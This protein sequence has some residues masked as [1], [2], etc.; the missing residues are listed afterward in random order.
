MQPVTIDDRKKELRMLLE[1]IQARPS[2]DWSTERERVVV[3][4]QMI[5]DQEKSA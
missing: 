2:H 4:K 5:A 3:L 1:K